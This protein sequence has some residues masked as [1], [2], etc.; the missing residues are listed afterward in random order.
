MNDQNE[1]IGEYR[2]R[3]EQIRAEISKEE[4]I[5][6]IEEVYH[7]H[8]DPDC[9]LDGC[10]D[11][12]EQLLACEAFAESTPVRDAYFDDKDEPNENSSVN[13]SVNDSGKRNVSFELSESKLHVISRL[14]E[15][16]YRTP[17]KIVSEL[18][19]ELFEEYSSKTGHWL[20]IAQHWPPRRINYA[21]GRLIKLHDSSRVTIHNAA[22]Y[23]TFLIKKRKVRK[24]L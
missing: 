23:F 6:Q 19:G 13:G 17:P 15:C 1:H 10:F 7:S 24:C 21:L 8:Y 22:A 16:N 20:Y 11:A 9:G 2:N 4:A 12:W 5:H 3:E 18:L 14:K